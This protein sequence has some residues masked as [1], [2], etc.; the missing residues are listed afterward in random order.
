M[1]VLELLNWSTN[2]L[3][4]YHIENPRLHAELLLAHSLNLSRERLYM[5]LQDQLKEEEKEA[6]ERLIQRRISGEPLQYIL[7]HQEFWSMGLKV[8]NRVLI[9]RP[10]TE[11]LV[12]QSLLL[13]CESRFERTPFVLEIGTGS[14]AIAMA[15][16]KERKDAFLVATDLSRDALLL[17]KE[18]ARSAGVQHQIEF[19]NGDLFEPFRVLK[20]KGPFDL[21]LSNPPYVN[22]H[23]IHSLAKEVKDYEPLMALDGGE[24]GLEFYR[25]IIS[26]AP[27]YLRRGGWILL[28]VGQG[29]SLR[30][31]KLMEEGGH[32][33]NPECVPD[34]SGIERVVKAQRKEKIRSACLRVAPPPEALRKAGEIRNKDAKL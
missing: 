30:V 32:F 17:A 31:S 14:G 6:L 19:V 33:L 25:R 15:M 27:L 22:R 5:N 8:D 21:I 26:Q 1:K 13:L 4:D 28:E 29:Q 12:E 34:L 24:D 11:L 10:E 2:C 18:N 3:K 9:P 23:E 16:A 20:K 7:E